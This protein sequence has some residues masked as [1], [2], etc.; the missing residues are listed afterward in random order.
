LS[1]RRNKELLG[2]QCLTL[3]TE[4][5]GRTMSF[6]NP[7]IVEVML[8]EQKVQ[9]RDMEMAHF[10]EAIRASTGQPIAGPYWRRAL[11]QL[12]HFLVAIS[13]RS[14]PAPSTEN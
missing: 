4:T 14:S 11:G 1:P 3:A 6:L 7:L 5:E 13:E 8:N 9:P 12:G 2:R 10:R